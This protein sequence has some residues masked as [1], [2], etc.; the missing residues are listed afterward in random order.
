MSST[1]SPKPS[2]GAMGYKPATSNPITN[3]FCQFNLGGD[4]HGGGETFHYAEMAVL[5]NDTCL[6]S[7]ALPLL[8]KKPAKDGKV[9]LELTHV[10]QSP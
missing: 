7:K 1:A 6:A 10:Q 5:I 9:L 3:R 8:G 4:A 2:T